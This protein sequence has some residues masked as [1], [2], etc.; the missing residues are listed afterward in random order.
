MGRLGLQWPETRRAQVNLRS[1]LSP[2]QHQDY[3]LVIGQTRH[4]IC[5][6]IAQ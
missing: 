5:I 1:A 6:I 3:P 2:D 4:K